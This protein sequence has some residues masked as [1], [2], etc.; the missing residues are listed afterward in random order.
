MGA[1]E[2]EEAGALDF[3]GGAQG[4]GLDEA[5]AV[6]LVDGLVAGGLV[7][8]DA[9][10]GRGEGLFVGEPLGVFLGDGEDDVLGEVDAALVFARAR[11]CGR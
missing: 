5:D 3:V 10:E 9:A 11:S 4:G 8:V 1:D 2:G 6:L 7:R